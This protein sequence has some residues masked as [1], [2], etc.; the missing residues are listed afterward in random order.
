MLIM[1][2]INKLIKCIKFGVKIKY[3]INMIF[4]YKLKI[5]ILIFM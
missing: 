3:F 4:K 5:V 1:K 2:Y